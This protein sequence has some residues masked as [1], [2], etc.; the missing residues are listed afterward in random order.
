[1][2]KLFKSNLV[3]GRDICRRN[4]RCIS[5]NNGTNKSVASKVRKRRAKYIKLLTLFQMKYLHN[6]ILN[7]IQLMHLIIPQI[8]IHAGPDCQIGTRS[9][10]LPSKILKEPADAC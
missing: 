2:S 3:K 5:S 7:N 1:M 10:F 9:A 8:F 4:F 6:A